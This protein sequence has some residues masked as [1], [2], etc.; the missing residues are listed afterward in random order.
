MQVN[1]I[2]NIRRALMLAYV[3]K[4]MIVVFFIVSVLISLVAAYNWPKNYTSHTTVYIEEE[5]ILG[6]L[7]QGTAVQTDVLDR[8]RI[9]REIIFGRK[10]MEKILQL[11]GWLDNEPTLLEQEYIMDAIQKRTTITNVGPNLV[12]ISYKDTNPERSYQ[13][14]KGFAD[15][16]TE[17]LLSTKAQESKSAFEFIYNQVNEYEQ[18]LKI[19][20]DALEKFRT[21]NVDFREG[22]AGEVTQRILLNRTQLENLEQELREAMIRKSSLESQLSGETE[23]TAGLSREEQIRGR[24]AELRSNLDTLRLSYHETYPDIVQIKTQIEELLD[25]LKEEQERVAKAKLSKSNNRIYIDESIRANPLYQQLQGDLY[26]TNTQIATLNTRIERTKILLENE[27]ERDKRINAAQAK[28]SSLTRDYNVNQEVYQDLLRRREN[29]RVSMNLDLEHQGVSINI[30]EPAYLPHAPSGPRYIHIILIGIIM[31]I[32]LPS[33]IIYG[34]NS[35]FG[36]VFDATD[37]RDDTNLLIIGEH[38]HYSSPTE[39]VTNK[40]ELITLSIIIFVTLAI[41]LSVSSY[42]LISE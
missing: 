18:K 42:R 26:E 1:N 39:I 8:A 37:I 15:L 21:E 6:P 40:K 27:L 23:S 13:I 17:G 41:V 16:F 12:R 2:E 24:I 31:G 28:L 5:N 10:I 3:Y 35:I 22:A 30:N 29:A 20:E 7:M 32:F 33:A 14:T 36:R 9:A 19:S 4:N 11:G 25:T 38:T 34:I